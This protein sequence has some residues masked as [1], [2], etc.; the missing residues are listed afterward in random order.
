MGRSSRD[1]AASTP[2]VW[3]APLQWDAGHTVILR[4]TNKTWTRKLFPTYA[5]GETFW[6]LFPM[7]G[8]ANVQFCIEHLVQL[9]TGTVKEL[10]SE[11]AFEQ[12]WGANGSPFLIAPFKNWTISGAAPFLGRSVVVAGIPEHLTEQKWWR[13]TLRG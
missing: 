6:G 2:P 8:E 5:F 1:V 3:R 13:N 11:V 10:V 12:L 4:P 9:L 7:G